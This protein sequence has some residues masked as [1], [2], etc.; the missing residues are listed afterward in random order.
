MSIK[1]ISNII[2]VC[3]IVGIYLVHGCVQ[4]K[5]LYDILQTVCSN[6]DILIARVLLKSRIENLEL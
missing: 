6:M 1:W 3:A 4:D 2:C 5:N